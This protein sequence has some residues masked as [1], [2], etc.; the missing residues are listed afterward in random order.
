MPRE[1]RQ[2]GWKYRKLHHHMNFVNELL[3]LCILWIKA[4]IS[5]CIAI[6]MILVE[7]LSSKSLFLKSYGL[8]YWRATMKMTRA[9]LIKGYHYFVLSNEYER[10]CDWYLMHSQVW[11]LILVWFR[12]AFPRDENLLCATK[13]DGWWAV[14][15]DQP[16]KR[17]SVLRIHPSACF[18]MDTELYCLDRQPVIW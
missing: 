13:N 9:W 12:K 2:A 3:Q 6:D 1:A 4:F 11:K 17:Y 5:V 15:H 14:R 7:H 16:N 18:Y 10:L 8:Q